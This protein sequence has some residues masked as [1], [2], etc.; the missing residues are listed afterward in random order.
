MEQ[1][2]NPHDKFFKEALSRQEA[3]VDFVV[4]YLPKDIA[5]LLDVYNVSRGRSSDYKLCSGGRS[6]SQTVP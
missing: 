1:I 4:H 3:A 2:S 5:S 6:I